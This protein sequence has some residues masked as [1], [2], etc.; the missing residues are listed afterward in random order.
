MLRNNP[1]AILRSQVA[2]S[3]CRIRN[4]IDRFRMHATVASRKH[5]DN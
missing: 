5:V 3:L 1:S 2:A 4:V